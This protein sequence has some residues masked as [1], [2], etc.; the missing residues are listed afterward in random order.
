M[1]APAE[2]TRFAAVTGRYLHPAE[3]TM[4]RDELAALQ[5]ARLRETLANA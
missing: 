5:L 1:G 2:P 3:E 4:S